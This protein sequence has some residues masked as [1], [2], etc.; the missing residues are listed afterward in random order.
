MKRLSINDI[1]KAS[2]RTGK[3]AYLSLAIG[4]FLSIFLVTSLVMTMR[5]MM[6]ATEENARTKYGKQEV[7]LFETERTEAEIMESGLHDAVGQVYVTAY[8]PNTDK[9]FGYYDETAEEMLNR[10]FIEGRMPEKPGE[11]AVE[12]H[13][14]DYLRS[15]AGA[16]GFLF[17]RQGHRAGQGGFYRC[18]ISGH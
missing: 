15:D 10:R 14:L 6:N 1:A 12:Q 17:W 3:R 9:V 11:I 16:G 18:E 4:I 7:V 13:V 8:L 5:G 2:L